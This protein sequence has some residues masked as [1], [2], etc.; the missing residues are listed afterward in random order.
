MMNKENVISTICL[1]GALIC[2]LV[3]YIGGAI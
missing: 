3:L 2:T 1:L